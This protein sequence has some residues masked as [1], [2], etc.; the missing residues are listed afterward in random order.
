MSSATSVREAGSAAGPALPRPSQRLAS[1][2]AFRGWTMFW[3]VGGGSMMI[4]LRALGHSQVMDTIV[5]QLAHS[6][7]QGLRYID[8]IWPSFMLMTGMSLPLSYA[9]HSLT[10]SHTE[11][12]LVVL[13]RVVA[14]LLLGSLRESMSH[15]RFYLVELSSALQPIAIAYLVAFLIVRRSWRFQATVGAAIL[16]GYALL[17]AFVPAYGVPA[18]SYQQ[19]ANLVTAVD[20]A[21]LGRTHPDGWGTVLSTIPTIATT[22]LGLLIGRLLVSDRSQGSKVLTIGLIGIAGVLLGWALDPAVPIIMKLWT[23]SYGLASAGWACLMFLPFYVVCDVWGYRKWAFPLAVIGMNA[24][25]IYMAQTLIPLRR[26]VNIYTAGAAVAMGT[27]GALFQ[28]V[29]VLAVEWLILYWMYKRK[30]F[31]TA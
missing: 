28:A 31:L 2:D 12:S 27:C 1:L 13:R 29:A 22:I 3:I 6:Q 9:K 5:Y 15:N 18:G 30:I 21:V 11:I 16:V 10:E 20:V 14:L 23:T 19:G 7:W 26:I 25:A 8:S 24:L 4:G 17:L